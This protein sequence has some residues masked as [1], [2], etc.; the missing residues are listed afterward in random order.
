MA[1]EAS[2]EE[3]GRAWGLVNHLDSVSNSDAQREALNKMLPEVSEFFSAIS[4]DAEI[5][6]SLKA[7]A[8]SDAVAALSDVEKRF[9][10]ETCEDFIQSGADLDEE[11][12]A[13]VAAV[14]KELSAR[15]QKF[16]ENVLDSTNAWEL[17][18]HGES[19]LAG[20]PEMFVE[21]AR[22]DALAKGH[23]SED[24]P[25]WRFSLQV[26]SFFPVMQHADDETL[27]KEIWEAS[28]SIGSNC[29]LYTSPSPR[30][31]G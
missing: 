20:I 13:K 26:T 30:D 1:L 5:W 27:R 31:R 14:S 11:Q 9:I 15:T 22:Q 23:G 4:L 12:K 18:V 24:D 16:S 28:T 19:R 3:L 6:S 25:K 8:E 21:G 10:S 2:T 29:L 7:F 17:I